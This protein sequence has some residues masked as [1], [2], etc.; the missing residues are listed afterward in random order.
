MS[1]FGGGSS[2]VSE[3]TEVNETPPEETGG[4]SSE[5][6]HSILFQEKIRPLF[7]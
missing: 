2:E 5:A 1:E 6:S 4:E 7:F 3:S